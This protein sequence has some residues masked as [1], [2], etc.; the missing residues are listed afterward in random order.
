MGKI[1]A[2]ALDGELDVVLVHKLGAPG[3]PELAIGAVSERG[4]VFLHDNA[5]RVGVSQGYVDREAE[6]QLQTLRERR[7]RYTPERGAI[8]PEG[9][10]VIVVDDGVATGSTMKAALQTVRQAGPDR[11]IVAIAVAPEDTVK[12]LRAQADEVICLQVPR[13]FVAVGQAFMEFGPVTDD[14]A[15]EMLRSVRDEA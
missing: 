14:E 10:T 2:D 1:V 12:S 13:V 4:E 9:R 15:I 3:N 8:R 6:T 7:E 11:L 5:R